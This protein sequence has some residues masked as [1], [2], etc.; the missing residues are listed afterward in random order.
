MLKAGENHAVAVTY[1]EQALTSKTS[2]KKKN[3]E[4]HEPSTIHI[5]GMNHAG[6]LGFIPKH[7]DE[8]VFY[9]EPIALQMPTQLG[10]LAGGTWK[11]T[12]IACGH[13][14]TLIAVE[15]GSGSGA[16]SQVWMESL[17]QP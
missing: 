14:H 10:A 6:Q 12:G 15:Y 17:P 13:A 11:V 2:S 9:N 7:G 16:G 3:S 4:K 8:R 5:W 1:G